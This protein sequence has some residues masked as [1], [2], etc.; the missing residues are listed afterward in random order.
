[1]A[2]VAIVVG[3]RALGAV[4]VRLGQ[5]RIGGEMLAGMLVGGALLSPWTA[6]GSR[7]P[8]A[9]LGPSAVQVIS[10]LGQI[11]MILYLLLVGLSLSPVDLRRNGKTIAA[12]SVPLALAAVAVAPLAVDCFS[13]AGWR[14]APGVTG[15]A[16]MAAAL[17]IS[18]FPFIAHILG[19][20]ELLHGDFAATAL[21]ASAVLATVALLLLAVAEHPLLG[22]LTT[23]AAGI[24][25]VAVSSSRAPRVSLPVGAEAGLVLAVVA[26]LAAAWVSLKLLGTP[27][28]GAFL[29][30][31]VLSQ[32]TARRGAIE[33]ALGWSVPVILVPVFLAGAGAR[34]DPRVLDLGVL[35]GA[36]VFTALLGTVAILGASVS[37][38]LAVLGPSEVSSI[39]A[40]LNCRGMML[41]AL[42]VELLDHRL[43]G[44]RLLAVFY[45]CALATTIMTGPLF[46]LALGGRHR[47]RSEALRRAGAARAPEDPRGI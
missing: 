28:L 21:G 33:R 3:A 25:A 9:V 46:A 40:L 26:A 42:G 44:S 45:L 30:G 15:V 32:S 12:T 18:G 6:E 20:R 8:A 16:V 47:G 14:L 11:G 36:A 23:A 43:I 10:E 22:L 24:A 39:A 2:L 27:L 34:V 19:E 13:G 41:L 31:I 7:H 4:A 37:S 5:P 1:M 17:T 35:A 29:V 38:R